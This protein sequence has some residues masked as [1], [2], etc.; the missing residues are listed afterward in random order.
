VAQAA[1]RLVVIDPV[2]DF[3]DPSV[4]INSEASVRR[5]YRAVRPMLAV[6]GGRL[7]C[8][9]TPYGRRGFFHDAWAQGGDDWH[10]IEV[11]ASRASAPTPWLRSAGPWASP[12]T[13]RSTAVRSAHRTPPRR[14]RS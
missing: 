11:P 9:S 5:L 4:N 10:R 1:A 14:R 12:G 7:V 13:A 2:T 6:S 3:L 8:L